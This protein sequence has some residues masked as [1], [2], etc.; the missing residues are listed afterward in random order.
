MSRNEARHGDSGEARS[1]F[2][3]LKR[4]ELA[5]GRTRPVALVLVLTILC[6]ASAFSA[7]VLLPERYRQ[8]VRNRWEAIIVN[9]PN[10][11]KGR[12]GLPVGLRVSPVEPALRFEWNDDVSAPGSVE[13]R[14]ILRIEWTVEKQL[15]DRASTAVL[16]IEDQGKIQ[17]FPIEPGALMRGSRVYVPDSGDVR[18]RLR[19]MPEKGAT[20]VA[21]AAFFSPEPTS[22][23]DLHVPQ[24]SAS[25]SDAPAEL[26]AETAVQP[27]PDEHAPLTEVASFPIEVPPVPLTSRPEQS[28]Q[29]LEREL[30][31]RKS[32]DLI[33]IEKGPAVP[34]SQIGN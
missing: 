26:Q 31:S 18:L 8:A 25:L 1:L 12:E 29:A 27:G 5:P 32:R 23:V 21:T 24:L 9:W 4:A 20:E 6:L 19:I 11:T 22:G 14:R 34:P 13:A 17:R 33:L 2:R 30:A 10:R 28:R 3:S 7:R 16:E 15:A